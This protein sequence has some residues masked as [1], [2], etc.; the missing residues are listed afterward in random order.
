MAVTE[1]L[2][3]IEILANLAQSMLDELS[4]LAAAIT[5][6]QAELRC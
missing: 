2:N 1:T 6:A 5:E 3:Q 4:L